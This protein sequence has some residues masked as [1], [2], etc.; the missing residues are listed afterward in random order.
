M[1]LHIAQVLVQAGQVAAVTQGRGEHLIEGCA[2]R[3]TGVDVDAVEQPLPVVGRGAVDGF[4]RHAVFF[5][6][7]RLGQLLPGSGG[8][9]EPLVGV[10]G[11]LSAL[12]L[13]VQPG[14]LLVGVDDLLAGWLEHRGTQLTVRFDAVDD[15][16]H[17]VAH[18]QL[19]QPGE[20]GH[21]LD[22]V[23][24][25]ADTQVLGAAQAVL[26]G[27][28]KGQIDHLDAGEPGRRCKVVIL[29]HGQFG[30]PHIL[31]ALQDVHPFQPV[32]DAAVILD[33]V[34]EHALGQAALHVV[35]NGKVA[36]GITER[37]AQLFTALVGLP[38]AAAQGQRHC[39]DASAPGREHPLQLGVDP[40]GAITALHGGLQLQ[41]GQPGQLGTNQGGQVQREGLGVLVQRQAV[42]GC[43]VPV[44]DGPLH[45]VGDQ[46][47]AADDG[48]NVGVVYHAFRAPLFCQ[49]SSMA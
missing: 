41:G 2:V 16:R 14:I 13:P 22:L 6:R 17:E 3:N 25:G 9:E 19:F 15:G 48:F 30:V 40:V 49:T 45:P 38:D 5:E 44:L 46:R 27:A 11:Q 10:H 47:F 21:R 33:G 34:D 39:E 28:A 4:R 8:L 20:V 26:G 1:A 35:G 18:R 31:P 32:V 43:V 36:G 7:L 24:L 29:Q 12:I 37:N 42:N 23:P